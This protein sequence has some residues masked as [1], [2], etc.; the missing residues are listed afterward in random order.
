MSKDE[1]H[2]VANLTVYDKRNR[3]LLPDGEYQLLMHEWTQNSPSKV[4]HVNTSWETIPDIEV[5]IIINMVS[6]R[7]DITKNA[8][9]VLSDC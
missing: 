6:I 2:F 9:T 8:L 4:S 7:F 5:F 3:C 1:K